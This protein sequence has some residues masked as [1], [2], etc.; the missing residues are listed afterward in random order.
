[1][2]CWDVAQLYKD[3]V[4]V[5]GAKG[6]PVCTV[7]IDLPRDSPPPC[8]STES[9]VWDPKAQGELH[10]KLTQSLPAPMV[11]RLKVT[12]QQRPHPPKMFLMFPRIV[13]G[14]RS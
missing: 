14:Y 2:L 8:K 5:G 10:C 4:P 11:L 6:N 1:M 3:D 7:R 9:E 12:A 13:R